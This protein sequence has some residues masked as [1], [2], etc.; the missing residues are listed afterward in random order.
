MKKR[1]IFIFQFFLIAAIIILISCNKNDDTNPPTMTLIG[2]ESVYSQKDSTYI[3]QGATAYDEEDGDITSKIVVT[4]NINIYTEGTYHVY[5]N[6][7]DNAGNAA[8]Q[9]TRTVKIL[10]F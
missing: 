9:I 5:Y 10:I 8:P 6:V 3:D 1:L 7:T 4:D 2:N